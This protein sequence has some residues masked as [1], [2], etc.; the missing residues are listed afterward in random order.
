[1]PH[2]IYKSITNS[3]DDYVR[4]VINQKTLLEKNG[5]LVEK[6]FQLGKQLIKV[7]R[8]TEDDLGPPIQPKKKISRK[9]SKRNKRKIST[10]MAMG[11]KGLVK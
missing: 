5:K 8:I 7:K 11:I 1:M 9:K 2:P 4:R 6:S 3:P 10:M